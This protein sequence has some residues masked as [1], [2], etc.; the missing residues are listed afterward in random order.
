M[1]RLE[2]KE[3]LRR[4]VKPKTK[5]ELV[6]GIREFWA[7]VSV[8]KCCKYIGHLKKVLPRVIELNGGPTGY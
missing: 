7:T 6:S 3:Y 5:D 1:A 2:L 8:T 4:E